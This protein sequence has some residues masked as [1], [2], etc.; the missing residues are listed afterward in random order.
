MRWWQIRKR[1]ADLEREIKSDLELEEE[2][3]RERGISAEEARYAARRAFGNPTLIH[4]QTHATWGWMG[5][6]NLVRDIRIS[7][8]T[9]WRSPGFSLIAVLVMA[10]CIGASVSLFTVVRSVLLRPLPFRD[11]ARLVMVYERNH[12]NQFPIEY[13]AVSPADYY[14][15]RANTHGFADMA[16]WEGWSQ[17]NLTGDHGELPEVIHAGAATANFFSLLGVPMAMGRTFTEQEDHWDADTVVLTWGFFERRFAA[18]PAILGKRIHLDAKPFTVVGVLPR[19]FRF[20]DTKVQLWVP[21]RSITPPR[22]LHDHPWHQSRVVARLRPEVSLANAISQISAVQ[23]RL[24]LQHLDQ[25]VCEAAVARNVNDDLARNV[26]KPLLLLLYAVACMLMIGCLNVANLLVARGASRQKEIAIRGAL[27]AQRWALIRGQLAESVLISLAGGGIGVLLSFAAIQWLAHAWKDLPT[28]SGLHV[29]GPVLFF[30]CALVLVT[31]LLSG[32]LP[33]ISSTGKAVLAML[34]ASS[35]SIGGSLSRAALRKGMLIVEIAVTVVLLLA[36]GLLLKNFLQLR[37][38]NLGCATDNILTIVYSLPR[39]K[40][41]TADKVIGFHE[42]LTDRVSALPGVKAVGL[43]E[44]VP[45]TGDVE[46]DAFNIPEHPPRKAGEDQSVSLVRRADPGFFTT[47]QIPLLEGR[48]FTRQDTSDPAHPD[49]G[50]KVIINHEFARRY[51]P[52]EDPIGKHIQVPLWTASKFEIIGVVADTLHQVNEPVRPTFYT[53][54]LSNSDQD[55]TLVVR[56]AGNPLNFAL[57]IQE[58][59]AALDPELPVSNVLTM[60]QIIGDSLGNL[61]LIATLVLAFA[62]LSLLL[63]SVGLYGVLSYLMTQRMNE[64]G[65]RIALGAQ[66]TH[67]FR[68]MLFDG[69]RPALL[70]LALGLGASVGAVRLIRSMLYGTRPLDPAIFAAVAATLLF[71][72]ALACVFPAWRASRIDPMLALRSE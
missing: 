70:G 11:P 18:D 9:L 50:S 16:A 14:D 45:G 30:S 56:T 19:W 37:S 32:L 60:R 58:Q 66:R 29:D 55:E 46:W 40:Y 22:H 42:R 2:E 61:S 23:Y 49:R 71:V 68:L 38:V 59:I 57:P 36:A 48:F 65:I 8:R 4:E 31:T 21:Y 53:P 63:A 27:G 41:D 39:Q 6:E 28:A 24:H 12:T 13:S 54:A 17:F 5:W 26:K 52:G 62:L 15:W 43:G 47:L 10:L 3:Q 51:F 34:Q 44:T 25:P 1:N 67:V 7:F 20:P 72:A 33:A 69:V 64:L 35:R